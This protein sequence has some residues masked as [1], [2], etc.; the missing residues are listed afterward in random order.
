MRCGRPT[1]L[2]TG[3][4]LSTTTRTVN[5][6]TSPTNHSGA[7]GSAG[8]AGIGSTA[9]AAELSI[10]LKARVIVSQ[11]SQAKLPESTNHSWVMT[12]IAAAALATGCGANNPNGTTSWVKWWTATS[13]R[14]SGL[15]R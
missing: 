8:G 1:R 5:A 14:C 3:Q 13:T 9:A 12:T 7:P 6:I 2:R 11:F 10:A 4:K 15:G